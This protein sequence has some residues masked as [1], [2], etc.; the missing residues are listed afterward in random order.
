MSET[1]LLTLVTNPRAFF[2]SL[3]ERPVG[4]LVPALFVLLTALISA[5]SAYQISAIVAQMMPQLRGMGPV[6]GGIGA[7]SAL[8]VVLLMWVIYTAIFFAISMAFNGRGDFGRLLSYV[9]YGFLPQAIGGIVALVLSWSL[10]SNLRV[11]SITDPAMISEWTQSLMKDPSM[12]LAS[13]ISLLF[14]LWSANI[15]IFGVRSGRKLSTRD[16]VITVGIPV[17]LY[18]LYTI[19]TLVI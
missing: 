13:A 15:W 1:S 3:E 2:E 12:R 5:V 16:A 7:I 9:G 17:L 14:L 10:L 8:V 19:Y 11:P 6:I 4:L 18:V